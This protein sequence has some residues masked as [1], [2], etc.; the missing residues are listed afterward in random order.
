MAHKPWTLSDDD[1]H[2]IESVLP[3]SRAGRP[4]TDDRRVVTGILHS[5]STGAPFSELEPY[6]NPRSLETRFRRWDQDG[7]LQRICDAIGF[8]P[9]SRHER[10]LRHGMGRDV[11]SG[12]DCTKAIGGNCPCR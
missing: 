6:G 10:H 11:L 4:R 9:M 8:K 3:R 12:R 5:L 7:T 2:R 1:W